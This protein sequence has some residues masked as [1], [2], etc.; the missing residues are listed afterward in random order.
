ML[1]CPR[2]VCPGRHCSLQENFCA[3][4]GRFCKQGPKATFA[5]KVLGVFV[6]QGPQ[7]KTLPLSS[8]CARKLRK[9]GSCCGLQAGGSKLKRK[10]C[11]AACAT[12]SLPAAHPTLASC[13][14]YDLYKIGFGV[15]SKP[16]AKKGLQAGHDG[17]A[18]TRAENLSQE[19]EFSG[20]TSER[21]AARPSAG[22]FG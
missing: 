11:S 19:V 6:K 1:S 13:L 16:L 22:K 20:F 21:Y 10:L 3:C 18:K 17:T 12:D 9:V 2:C 4:A 15:S 8:N 5:K 14:A 7:N